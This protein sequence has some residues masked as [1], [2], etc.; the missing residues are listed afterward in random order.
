MISAE[1]ATSWET[2]NRQRQGIPRGEGVRLSG[3]DQH[4]FGAG[5]LVAEVQGIELHVPDR[6][7]T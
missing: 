7:G 6:F 1:V 3:L 2:V 4:A 5:D